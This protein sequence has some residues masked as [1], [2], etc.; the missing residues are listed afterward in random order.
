MKGAKVFVA[1]GAGLVGANLVERLL[2]AGA[3]VS[4]SC[5][6]RLASAHR[7]VYRRLE[8]ARFEDCLT[9]TRG[10]D[11]VFLAAARRANASAMQNN[12]TAQLLPNL[13]VQAGLLEACARNRVG[14]VV[15]I[16]SSTL[17]QEVEHPLKEEELD[18]NRP[19]HRQHQGVGWLNR[20]VEQLALYYMQAHRMSV[21]I[22]RPTNIFG[23]HDDF[24]PDTANV[25]PALIR[26]A[27]EREDPFVVWGDG[28][29]VRDFLFVDDFI[30][31]LLTWIEGGPPGEPVNMGSGVAMTVREAV[32]VVLE[33]CGH[34]VLPRYDPAKPASIPYRMLDLSRL[35]QRVGLRSRTPFPKAVQRT[36][37]WYQA[38]GVR[39]T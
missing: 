17:Y 15:L 36:F 7:K 11:L 1:G 14:R 3:C 30:A 24:E 6:K 18:L 27:A 26:R 9:A 10:M 32:D 38:Q 28:T 16:S 13:Q 37:D 21:W 39:Q 19:M 31:D 20:Y 22:V 29:A 33:V 25:I 2:D 5:H 12:P 34:R 23:P 35:K 4:A 8:L